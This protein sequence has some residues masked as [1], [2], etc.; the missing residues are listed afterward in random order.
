MKLNEQLNELFCQWKRAMKNNAHGLYFTS[1]GLM[2]K[3]GITIEQTDKDW[4]D[5][6]CR[7]MFIAKDNPG[8]WSDD[9]R[10]WLRS[11]EDDMPKHKRHKSSNRN[12]S[13]LFLKRIAYLLWGIHHID[14]DNP[15]WCDEVDLHFEEVKDFF[16]TQPFAFVEAKKMPGG[17]CITDKRLMHHLNI[18]GRFLYEEIEILRPT[19]IICFGS[20]ILVAVKEFY[21]DYQQIEIVDAEGQRSDNVYIPDLNLLL[22]CSY[23]PSTRK[24]NED[25]YQGCTHWYRAFLQQFPDYKK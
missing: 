20:P 24:S 6:P 4:F 10:Y 14:N 8:E 19:I 15:W 25:F 1:D 22:L 17:S 23:H 2:Y 5:S 13:N 11:T 12:L 9:T 18:Y 21:A 3:E 16:N 7:V